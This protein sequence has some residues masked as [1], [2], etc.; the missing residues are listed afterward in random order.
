MTIKDLGTNMDRQWRID[1]NDN[2]RELSGF[3][4]SATNALSKANDAEQQSISAKQNADS[5]KQLAQEA[6]TKADSAN[7]TSN[8]VQ[9]QLNQ[10]VIE[11]DSSVEAA[12]A[13][14][15][16]KGVL[17][18]TLKNRMDAD[19]TKIGVLQQ[20]IPIER[21][22]QYAKI[23][24]NNTISALSRYAFPTTFSLRYDES[25]IV[26]TD[27][28]GGYVTNFDVSNFRHTGGKTVYVDTINGLSTND[29]LSRNTPCQSVEKALVLS[30]N[31]DTILIINVEGSVIG[32]AGWAPDGIIT[33]NVN[34]IAENKIIIF[35]GDIPSWTPSPGYANVYEITRSFVT[36]LVD[37]NSINVPVEYKKVGSVN[38]V[39][40]NVYSWYCDGTKT[41]VNCGSNKVPNNKVLPLLVTGKS[42][43]SNAATQNSKIY[44][45]NL[46]L[47]GGDKN[48]HI[49]GDAN[50][51]A[52]ELYT[53]NC[54]F[55][56]STA[57]DA[58]L[59]Q[60]AKRSYHQ[61][62][63]AAYSVKD[64][65]NYSTTIGNSNIVDFIEVN[66][67]GFANGDNTINTAN[68]H[69]GSTAH[70]KSRGVKI[71]CTYYHNVGG[72]LIDVQGVK[73]VNLGCITF[74]S[75]SSDVSYSH[76]MGTQGA[77]GV[78]S[79]E[80]WFEGC[81]SFGNVSDVYVPSGETVHVRICQYDTVSGGGIKDFDARL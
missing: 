68:T 46:L 33:K 25:P 50:F 36:R 10:I 65:F 52:H 80:L 63:I 30:S 70:A 7:N 81:I 14:L 20:D 43:V 79:C 78:E 6:K 29:G 74:N 9:E 73:S 28:K 11:G 71:N 37:M 76:G 45:E 40:A 2:F 41:Y 31:G 67:K 61:N 35:K 51:N 64:G 1:L 34:I 44:L 69:N 57:L 38:E 8:S 24:K 55:Y 3:T 16:E 75:R 56:F 62:S 66:C 4:E 15:D 32:R 47:V 21:Q 23:I 17:H 13:R 49:V 19:S 26:F 5:A 12:Q 27:S 77:Q 54:T 42:M 18:P 39:Q 53:K 60:N 22:R 48:V 59:T 72:Q 58:V